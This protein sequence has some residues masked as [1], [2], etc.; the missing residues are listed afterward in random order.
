MLQS[1]ILQYFLKER[2]W[3]VHYKTDKKYIANHFEIELRLFLNLYKEFML[4]SIILLL[5][6]LFF[7]WERKG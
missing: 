2:K 3:M 4:K 5:I 6:L 7:S 1:I